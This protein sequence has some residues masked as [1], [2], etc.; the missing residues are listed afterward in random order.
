MTGTPHLKKRCPG[1]D[2]SNN[3]KLSPTYTRI[4]VNKTTDRILTYVLTP[5]SWLYGAATWTRNKLF[6]YGVLKQEEFDVPVV[7]IGNITVGGTGKTPHVEYIVSQL[8][9]LYHIAVLSRGYK[10]RTR[11]FIVANS[12]STP[13]IVGD[14]P[15]QIYQK[16]GSRIKVAVCESRR[17]GI[18]RLIETYPNLD[19]I[20]LDDAF[21]HRYVKP[22]VS[23][24]LMDYRRPVYKDNL[25][26]LG[27]LRESPRCIDR[28]DMVVVTKCPD[29]VT[30]LDLRIV[31]KRLDLMSDQKLFFSRYIYGNLKPVFAEEAPPR[32][33]L[34]V[35]NPTDTVLLLTGVANPRDF[36]RH[37]K[38]YAFK[39][40][41]AHYPD[42]HDFS[43]RDITDIDNTFNKLKGERKLIVTT[44]KDAVRL[45]HNPYFPA[46]LKAC[47]YY[48]PIAVSMI[49]GGD[50]GEFVHVLRES[51]DRKPNPW[52]GERNGDNH[53]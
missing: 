48:L 40:K 37:F 49:S 4:R 38:N 32:I 22:K 45:L 50:D 2:E 23:I 47:I 8:S 10:R 12:K 28:A 51:I 11:G 14:E 5:L 34:E 13:E 29:E 41:V 42:H 24:M 18:R 31:R 6:D 9:G 15:L 33:N 25:L 44:E 36:I 19:L 27:R 17:E 35:L 21:Q 46:Y 26:P 1:N 3:P 30:P 20:I 16:F 43:R 52:D 53:I 7:S 39:R